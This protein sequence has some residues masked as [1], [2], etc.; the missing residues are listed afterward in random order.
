MPK[1]WKPHPRQREMLEL[2]WQHVQSVPYRVSLRWLF[3]RLLADAFY[4][5][6]G[7][8]KGHFMRHL[9]TARREWYEGWRPWTLEDDTRTP[10]YRGWGY[11]DAKDWLEH[12][13]LDQG[14]T[15]DRWR[16]QPRYVE[17]WFEARAMRSQFEHY[18][19]DII[20]RPFGGDPSIQF[21]WN[22][23]PD[24]QQVAD[25]YPGKPRVMLYFGDADDKGYAIPKDAAKIIRAWGCADFEVVRIGLNPGDGE[26]LGMTENPDKPGSYQ[27]EGLT[28][29]QARV[30]ITQAVRR[31]VD[32]EAMAAIAEE[33]EQV[34]QRFR[35]GMRWLIDRW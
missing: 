13:I 29:D 27:W 15:L 1:Q 22:I 7:Q 19:Q 5:R 12:H 20:L 2:A 8:Y 35:K 10:V 25:R 31:Y 17:I 4:T 14:A 6:K 9:R 3:Y 26:R 21:K 11:Q 18:T 34:T 28:N 23:V 16:D 32:L 33:E 24:L 30:I